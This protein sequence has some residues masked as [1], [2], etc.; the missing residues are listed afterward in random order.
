MAPPTR[1]APGMS[2]PDASRPAAPPP[3]RR[4][5]TV[6][7]LLF[8]FMTVNFMDKAVLGLAGKHVKDDLGL[9]DTA[10]GLIGSAFFLLF[11]VSGVVLGFLADRVSARRLLTALVVAWSLA[12]LVVAL[13]TAGLATLIV[14]RVV[15]GAAEGPAFPL[16]NHT[17][18]GWF[19]DRERAVPGSLLTVGGATGIAVGGPLLAVV[20]SQFGWRAAFALTGVLGLIW[21]IAWLRLGGEGPYSARSADAASDGPSIPFRRLLLSGTALGGLVCGFAGFWTMAVAITW[22][23]QFLQRVHGYSLEAA[24]LMGAGTQVAGIVVVL[25]VGR[26]SQRMVHAGRSSR[27]ARGVLGGAAVAVSGLAALLL[28]RVGGGGAALVVVMLV[29]FTLVN[30][31]FGLLAAVLAEIA[32]VRRRAALLGAVTAAA[33][34]AGAIGPALTGALVDHGGDAATG[35]QHAFDL[36]AALMIVGGLLAA[37]LIRPARDRAALGTTS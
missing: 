22:L 37:A 32:P 19:P 4:A 5:W 7:A 28:T 10:F 9:D 17:A 36:T 25:A 6:V 14:T 31:F 20:I 2:Q 34:T 15:L 1:S 11:S 12:Q 29:A 33:A 13:P 16:A 26:A 18:F 3:A 21:A 23:P 30:S 35:F 8:L 24:S 27:V